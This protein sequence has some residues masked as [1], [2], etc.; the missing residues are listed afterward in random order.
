MTTFEVWVLVGLGGLFFT[1]FWIATALDQANKHYSNIANRILD[2][3][4][5]LKDRR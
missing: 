3:W 1:T 4:L 2:I 5:L